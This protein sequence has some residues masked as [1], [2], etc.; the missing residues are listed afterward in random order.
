M[1]RDGRPEGTAGGQAALL[2]RRRHGSTLGPEVGGLSLS[3]SLLSLSLSLHKSC[4]HGFLPNLDRFVSTP[5]DR[6]L[7]ERARV[8]LPTVT[9]LDP[10][11]D[12]IPD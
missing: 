5:F 9:T 8:R 2:P 4:Q 1:E 6:P 7:N 10:F 3:L 11:A 12:W